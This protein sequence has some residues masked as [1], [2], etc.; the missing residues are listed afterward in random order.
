LSILNESYAGEI[1]LASSLQEQPMSLQFPGNIGGEKWRLL[2]KENSGR[3]G[4]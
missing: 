3:E 2:Y 4:L 1:S